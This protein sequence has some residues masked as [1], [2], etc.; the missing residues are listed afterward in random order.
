MGQRLRALLRG[1]GGRA[2]PTCVGQTGLLTAAC[3]HSA[4]YPHARGANAM[5]LAMTGI[6][7]RVIPTRVGQTGDQRLVGCGLQSYPHVCGANVTG[8]CT[9]ANGIGAIPTHVGQFFGSVFLHRAFSS[10]PHA[11]GANNGCACGGQSIEE[12]SPRTWGKWS[13]PARPSGGTRVIPTHVGQ[14]TFSGESARGARSYPHTRGAN[15][16]LPAKI[17]VNCPVFIQ[18]QRG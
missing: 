6:A 5:L 9:R 3:A 12:S 11:R 4:S 10:H 1:S 14:I 17:K 15:T 13:S 8:L 18:L 2:I 7:D 16:S